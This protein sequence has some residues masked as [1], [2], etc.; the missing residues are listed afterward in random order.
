MSLVFTN[1]AHTL[2]YT[3]SKMCRSLLKWLTHFCYSVHGDRLPKKIVKRL[4]MT[5]KVVFKE[6]S[7]IQNLVGSHCVRK[8]MQFCLVTYSL[9]VENAYYPR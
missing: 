8:E 5:V 6:A 1:T 3:V 2:L 7:E 4:N 9:K